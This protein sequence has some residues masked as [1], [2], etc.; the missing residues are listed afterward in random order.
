MI[1]KKI[2][3]LFKRN[4]SYNSRLF[5]CSSKIDTVPVPLRSKKV[6][7]TRDKVIKLQSIF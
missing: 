2:F 1:V 4:L 6:K 7:S 5:F 3:H